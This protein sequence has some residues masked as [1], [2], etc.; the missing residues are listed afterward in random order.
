MI[1]QYF[2]RPQLFLLTGLIFGFLILAMAL[3]A[4]AQDAGG[5]QTIQ[6]KMQAVSAVSLKAGNYI[7]DLWGVKALKEQSLLEEHHS[8]IDLENLASN[9]D[10]KCIPRARNGNRIVAQ[11][12]TANDTDIA[13]LLLKQGNAT[14]DRETVAGQKEEGAYYKAEQTAIA[15]GIGG[16][17]PEKKDSG[18]QTVKSDIKL[19]IILSFIFFVLIIA[20]LGFI[21]YIINNGFA[22]IEDTLNQNANLMHKQN[23]LRAKEREL[24]AIMLNSELHT[25]H[26]KLEAFLVIYEELLANL[27]DVSI[28]HKY[29]KSGEIVRS[30]PALDRY[31][32][33]G[34]TDKLDILGQRLAEDV[35]GFYSHVQTNPAFNNLEPEMEHA[36]AIQTVENVIKNAK[37]LRNQL[38]SLIRDFEESGFQSANL[39]F[40]N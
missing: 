28:E 38:E 4:Y 18:I 27:K 34:N 29:R 6:R 2:T 25:N 31:I 7:I 17:I 12:Y 11:C 36:E 1:N 35:I 30:A 24:V 33:D 13:L 26:S 15:S 5:A 16:W 21:A 20:S 23:K 10:T 32:F 9:K 40:S 22:Q 14:V 3:P 39:I 37:D 19:V 8:R